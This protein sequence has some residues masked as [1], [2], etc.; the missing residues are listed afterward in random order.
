MNVPI[1]KQINQK[2]I[3]Y[4]DLEFGEIWVDV[5]MT[6]K[7][8]DDE[9]KRNKFKFELRTE[10]NPK[11]NK[12]LETNLVYF[13]IGIWKLL[14]EKDDYYLLSKIDI[15]SEIDPKKEK[16]VDNT[17]SNK[18]ISYSNINQF[19]YNDK[20]ICTLIFINFTNYITEKI[21]K[22]ISLKKQNWSFD[23]RISCSFIDKREKIKTYINSNLKSLYLD[24]V[25][26]FFEIVIPDRENKENKEDKENKENKDSKENKENKEGNRILCK[27]EPSQTGD[28]SEQVN[29]NSANNSPKESGK[30]KFIGPY[31][32]GKSS[33]NEGIEMKEIDNDN[34]QSEKYLMIK[35]QD[36]SPSN[37]IIRSNKS[38]S[39]FNNDEIDFDIDNDNDDDIDEINYIIN[40]KNFFEDIIKEI[41][42]YTLTKNNFSDIDDGRTRNV[43]L[44]ESD[45]QKSNSKNE[46]KKKN[47]KDINDEEEFLY[48][49][50]IILKKFVGILLMIIFCILCIICDFILGKSQPEIC[51]TLFD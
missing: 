25:K 40:E 16:T 35:K 14:K 30:K 21:E 5:I 26:N 19:G 39:I 49:R 15:N 20:I 29:N 4:F 42:L 23:Q 7:D 8:R 51:P 13:G 47:R 32:E 44:L 45:N 17:K 9:T 36:F 28:V 37:F 2:D 12:D 3:I 38:Q 46:N 41:E 6:V 27:I 24:K 11:N 50:N 33:K 1:E 34:D 22:K 43:I 10:A 18:S 31:S 48:N